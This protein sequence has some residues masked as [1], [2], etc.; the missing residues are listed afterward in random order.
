M[1]RTILLALLLA[2]GTARASDWV[3][4]GKSDDGQQEY[5]VDVSSIRVESTS[6]MGPSRPRTEAVGHSRLLNYMRLSAS[7]AARSAATKCSNP[8]PSIPSVRM[9]STRSMAS[10]YSRQSRR[11]SSPSDGKLSWRFGMDEMISVAHEARS[12]DPPPTSV[13]QS[14]HCRRG[15]GSS[16]YYLRRWCAVDAERE[17]TS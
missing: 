15:L 2:C 10:S 9:R 8:F 4:L 7:W 5:F 17:E 14:I 16:L 3:S 1:N 6:G 13:L 11:S 12:R